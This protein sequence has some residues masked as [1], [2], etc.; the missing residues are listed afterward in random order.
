ML[1]RLGSNTGSEAPQV[2]SN[3]K[4]RLH[5]LELPEVG[6]ASG[7]VGVMDEKGDAIAISSHLCRFRKLLSQEQEVIG[8]RVTIGRSHSLSSESLCPK[9]TF[10]NTGK[11]QDQGDS[12]SV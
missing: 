12:M 4:L 1:T 5:G 2:L 11:T 9:Q 10:K 3:P 7:A 8:V 6:G